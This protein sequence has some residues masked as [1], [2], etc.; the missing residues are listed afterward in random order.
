MNLHFHGIWRMDWG[1]ANPNKTAALIVTLLFAV[2]A[3]A[4]IWRKGFWLSL[5]LSCGLGVLLI[6]TFSRG[7]VAA[8]GA[9]VITLLFFAPRPWPRERLIGIVVCTW[10]ILGA[11]VYLQANERFTQGIQDRS[12]ANRLEIWRQVPKMIADAPMGW[13][14][15]NAV[16]AYQNWYQPLDHGVTYLN[17]VST[18][19]TWLVEFSWWQRILYC[20]GWAAVGIVCWPP[21]G[22]ETLSWFVVPP[23]TAPGRSPQLWPV[24]DSKNGHDRVGSFQ[25]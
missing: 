19:F 9:G 23:H 13:G 12:I 20:F 16:R 15:G 2:W 10:I 17:L 11:T 3:F 25:C 4:F 1:F 8:L 21:K 18:H 7:G 14:V 22:R 6:H 5:S 24:F